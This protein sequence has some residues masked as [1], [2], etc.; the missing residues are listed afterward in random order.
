M[1][2]TGVMRTPQS[3]HHC[4]R[5]VVSRLMYALYA[6]SFYHRTSSL[7]SCPDSINQKTVHFVLFLTSVFFYMHQFMFLDPGIA[8]CKV[9]ALLLVLTL[10]Q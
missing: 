1:K 6:Q 3:F 2:V 9:C 5:S 4:T 8:V 7:V 10:A